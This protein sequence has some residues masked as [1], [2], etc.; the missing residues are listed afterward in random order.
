MSVEYKINQLDSSIKRP[1]DKATADYTITSKDANSVAELEKMFAQYGNDD[2]V[3]IDM[4]MF[5][6]GS[7]TESYII[8]NGNYK[9][10]D[11][12]NLRFGFGG[13]EGR[14]TKQLFSMAFPDDDLDF[15]TDFHHRTYEGVDMDINDPKYPGYIME[16]EES[17]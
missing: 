5:T 10:Y 2:H 15:I 12:G 11:E 8:V 1:F 6:N 7:D 13:N 14:E 4:T 3:N 17:K 16:I 9:I